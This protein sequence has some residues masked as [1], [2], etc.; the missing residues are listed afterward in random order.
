[1]RTRSSVKPEMKTI[2]KYTLP[3]QDRIELQIPKKAFRLHVGMQGLDLQLWALIDTDDEVVTRVLYI[4][5][6]GKP[7]PKEADV[8]LGSVQDRQFVW[9]VFTSSSDPTGHEQS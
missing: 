2:Y 4:V 5:G 1:M 8:F 7:L 3:I 6:T 9:H